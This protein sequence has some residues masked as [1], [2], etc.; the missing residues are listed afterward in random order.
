MP[1]ILPRKRHYAYPVL[2]SLMLAGF[3][4]AATAED[5]PS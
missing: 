5:L 3:A 1:T 4:G 2:L